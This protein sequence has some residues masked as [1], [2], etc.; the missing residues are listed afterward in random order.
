MIAPLLHSPAPLQGAALHVAPLAKD[1][2]TFQP[3]HRAVKQ[4]R[5]R[6]WCLKALESC[7]PCLKAF[8]QTSS[9]WLVPTLQRCVGYHCRI[10]VCS[11]AHSLAVL[12]AAV[13]AAVFSTQPWV[14]M[15]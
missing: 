5:V 7:L 10:A 1:P 6:A 2:N 4:A 15:H 13:L 9:P 11:F 14:V 12:T 8:R 3:G